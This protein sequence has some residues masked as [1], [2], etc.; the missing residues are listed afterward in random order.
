MN[1]AKLLNGVFFHGRQLDVKVN[2]TP[3]TAA[4][5]PT[6]NSLNGHYQTEKK[7]DFE[8]NFNSNFTHRSELYTVVSDK[9]EEEP[10]DNKHEPFEH[11][12]SES[13]IGVLEKEDECEVIKGL[14]NK[15]EILVSEELVGEIKQLKEQCSKSNEVVEDYRAK[16]I[17]I[18]NLLEVKE[19]TCS[20]Q[21]K[22]LEE[23]NNKVD[24]LEGE[25]DSLKTEN[26]EKQKSNVDLEQKFKILQI[27]NKKLKD[28]I[29]LKSSF[30]RRMVTT[31]SK[32]VNK[33]SE[34]VLETLNQED[35][36]KNPK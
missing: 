36:E 17:K 12:E 5:W 23:L 35:E 29:K 9:F 31:N 7:L 30:I 33:Y 28:E 21:H 34:M 15:I 2:D 1:A 13:S 4:Q 22:Q 27:E 10:W 8:K 32:I 19:A 16:L 11:V 6:I 3:T 14:K 24:A 26:I 18:K 25:V 20:N